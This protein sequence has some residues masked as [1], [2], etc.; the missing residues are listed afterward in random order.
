MEQV[1]HGVG[2]QITEARKRRNLSRDQL[3]D[4][5]GISPEQVRLFEEDEERIPASLLYK[6]AETFDLPV[7]DFFKE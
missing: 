1:E 7:T 3:G 6:L 2:R 5:L 4:L